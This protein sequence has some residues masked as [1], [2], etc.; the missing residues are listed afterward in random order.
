MR[1][2]FSR[3]MPRRRSRNRLPKLL[4]P[5][6]RSASIPPL[7]YPQDLPVSLR[8]EEI[9]EAIRTRQVVVVSGA[10]GSGKSTQLPKMCLEAGLGRTGMVGHTQP[11]RIAARSLAARIAEEMNTSV[12]SLVGFKIRFTDQTAPS[13]LV[14]LMTDGILLAETQG[15]RD[16]RQYDAIIVDEA[17]ER[18]LNID[19]LLGYLHRLRSV[20]RDLKIIITSATIDAERF[21]D[22]FADGEG[23]APVIEV[24]G[25]SYPVEIRYLPWQESSDGDGDGDDEQ[26]LSRH[27]IA[28][29]DQLFAGAGGDTLVF[30]PTER[31]IRQCTTRLTG[32]FKRLGRLGSV[33]ILPLFARLSTA[34]Q[35]KIFRPSGNARRI[36]LATN[37]A[38]SS[39]TVPGIK[40]VV[41][42]GLARIS[43]YSPRSKVQRLPIEAVSR[44]SAD[45]R[46]GR[47]GRTS[48]GICIRLFSEDDYLAR[49]RFTTPEIRRTNLAAVILQATELRLGS[50]TDF[51]LLDPPREESIREGYHTLY[52]LGATDE[53]RRLTPIGRE[54]ARM[55]VD[56]RVG[57]MI[58]AS[59][60]EG[61]LPEVLVI[62]A[63]LELQDPRE[64]PHE[65]REAADAAHEKFT[66]PRSDFL[67][68]LRLWKFIHHLRETLSKN[69]VRK[70]CRT[71][72]LN[73]N[74]IQ[75]WTDIHRTLREVIR[76][77]SGR[78][79]GTSGTRVTWDPRGKP[80][81]AAEDKTATVEERLY[82]PIHRALLAGLPS[83]VAMVGKKNAYQGA[84][85]LELFL[86]PGSGLFAAKPAWV[87]AAELVETSRRYARTVAAIQPGW[88][89]SIVPHL[90]RR[91]YSDAHWSKKGR[92][93]SCFERVTLYGLPV[94]AR[95]RVALAP[96]DPVTARELLIEE[97][98]VGRQLQSN[99]DFVLHNDRLRDLV[100]QLA[101]KTRR[102]DLLVDQ[103][104][105]MFYA[106]R[107]PAEACDAPRLEQLAR[108]LQRPDWARSLKDLDGLLQWL[109]DPPPRDRDDTARLYMRP[110]DLLP[111]EEPQVDPSAF[112]DTLDTGTARLPLEYHFAPESSE[113]GI[114]VT[115][116]RA[117]L[118]QVSDNSLGWL[119]PGMLE[120]KL[121]ALI[122]ALPKRLRRL[123]VP[124]ADTATAVARELKP[125]FGTVPFMPAVCDA[126]SRIA[127]TTITPQDFDRDKMPDHLEFLVK[128]VDDAGQVL[129]E[130]RSVDELKDE[131]ARQPDTA[132]EAAAGDT[133][134]ADGLLQSGLTS[135]DLD[136]LPR[137]IERH[138]GGVQVALFP[139]L[140]D[141][142]N[143]VDVR[144][145]DTEAEADRQ[146]VQGL[147]RLFSLAARKDLKS[148]VSWLPE[149]ES[150]AVR[151]ASLVGGDLRQVLIDVLARLAFIE[152]EP[153]V[154]SRDAFDQRL[155][156]RGTRIA[157]ATQEIARWLPALAE[158]YHQARRELEQLDAR[159]F[160]AAHADIQN[161]LQGLSGVDVLIR[162][163]WRWLQH[164]PRYFRGIAVRIEKLRSG[165][166]DRDE[167]G[168]ETLRPFLAV[169][170]PGSEPAE[171]AQLEEIRWMTEELR[172]SLFAQQLGTAEKV[173][174]Q[175]L[176]KLLQKSR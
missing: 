111:E 39:L 122:K 94:V 95:R 135:F 76:E 1:L 128:V 24:S 2:T 138:R 79:G 84:G 40:Y 124:A 149:Y 6:E 148:Q 173:S 50:L 65:K 23:P 34:D 137:Q 80:G 108:S 134:E 45:Q 83:G 150:S 119:V 170:P 98:L 143:S 51:P 44:A 18:S 81:D 175:R 77:S 9:I 73:F 171:S 75:E 168:L 78:G 97:G 123:L 145:A 160:A 93:A 126:L 117:V 12:G 102:R 164:F 8:R 55:P 172:I 176:E 46:A 35:Q 105:R 11:R 62:A 43:R 4:S 41:D 3:T 127:E 10:T 144:L 174:P 28:A 163:P 82:A 85:G 136:Q 151:L 130:G 61:C 19:F 165:A 30:L 71:N 167:R 57:R 67:S 161:H 56:P 88:I 47:C 158:G 159:R 70:A 166:A 48:P 13:T 139:T 129:G 141:R 131:L 64:R 37:V 15:D 156:Q 53:S 113:D 17:H 58:L 26:D 16:L 87:V 155:Q 89:E 27:V 112:P 120:Q 72:F 52:E 147:L 169:L 21:A 104:V 74:R 116:P 101:R 153:L 7:E 42:S 31:D 92:G 25:R 69:Q 99:A 146:L 14:K 118:R 133:A 20:R 59:R 54:L 154:R 106:L 107:L 157:T 140:I 103:E 68:Y 110:D 125:Q 5:E 115:V 60:E 49:D 91:S 38:E 90:L 33:E 114:V 29:I 132:T 66:D 96:I 32:H 22:H 121:T 100:D 142:G 86:W 63:A 152:G 36:V 109:E 162:T